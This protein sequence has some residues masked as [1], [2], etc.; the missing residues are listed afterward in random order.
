MRLGVTTLIVAWLCA[1]SCASEKPKVPD[2]Q[3]HWT[4]QDA[5]Q[6]ASNVRMVR[7][8]HGGRMVFSC[9]SGLY[10]IAS[11]GRRSQPVKRD[12]NKPR[13][14]ALGRG[15][16]IAVV[17]S[18]IR[19]ID[20][21]KT[22]ARFERP[23]GHIV[24][25][26]FDD[27]ETR[28]AVVVDGGNVWIFDVKSGQALRGPE[29][30]PRP[31]PVRFVEAP[32]FR[33]LRLVRGRL[34]EI[35]DLDAGSTRSLEFAFDP[36]VDPALSHD[37]DALAAV[38][39]G[40]AIEIRD[41]RDGGLRGVIDGVEKPVTQ[42][43]IS[44]DGSL[45]AA[46]AA[47]KRVE[48]WDTRS[49]T[50]LLGTSSTFSPSGR[51]QFGT[52]GYLLAWTEENLRTVRVWQPV[53]D[54]VKFADD[55]PVVTAGARDVCHDVASLV[56]FQLAA[57]LFDRAAEHVK[58]SQLREA[59][60]LLDSAREMFGDYPGL[61]S[62]YEEIDER[63]Q[64]INSA[65]KLATRVNELEVDG[66][67]AE[68]LAM[69][70][71]Y[72]RSVSQ[73]GDFG[74]GDRAK[75]LRTMLKHLD[76]AKAKLAASKDVDAVV[77]FDKAVALAPELRERFSEY[78]QARERADKALTQEAMQA[79]H[80]LTWARV[81]ELYADLARLRKLDSAENL[82]LGTSL[83][84]L[85]NARKAVEAFESIEPERP[86]YIEARRNLARIAIRDK[87]FAGALRQLELARSRAKDLIDLER[88]YA[89]AQ[90][91][92]GN[93]DA[94]VKA[95]LH[96]AKLEPSNPEPL[97]IVA[98]IEVG[99]GNHGK[100]ARMLQR[101][102]QVSTDPRPDL[103]LK[104]VKAYEHAKRKDEVL[105]AYIGLL[106]LVDANI[107]IPGL[108]DRPRAELLTKIRKLG[109]VRRRGTWITRERFLAEQGWRERDGIWNRPEEDDLETQAARIESEFKNVE[110]RTKTDQSYAA[111]AKD[112]RL[113]VGMNRKEIIEAWGLFRDQNVFVLNE[114]VTYEQL[115]FD[116][117]RQAYLRNGL[118]AYW[119]E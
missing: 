105:Q 58:K 52:D 75:R 101:A 43:R 81:V 109:Y 2:S 39:P 69:L 90:E 19:V 20:H 56:R 110:L 9:D 97:E 60:T 57:K 54:V 61:A 87:D 72:L 94:A 59:R 1:T 98:R 32:G 16:L 23:S 45:L 102:V 77:E 86:E 31:G 53:N 28:L 36:S 96:V 14:V 12:A 24:S 71:T 3:P 95:W 64:A 46:V 108:G 8:G 55:G 70:D 80:D 35:I 118:L 78:D 10:E 93:K 65:E 112:K 76:V 21:E 119:S 62:A 99:R 107:Q 49:R 44:P 17:G 92:N 48:L 63:R 6:A 7:I 15:G 30:M 114:K 37:G 89:Q 29:I 106:Q 26:G 5:F 18:E 74:L 79:F 85:G 50:L 82:R 34:I 88:E 41:G 25:I 4:K 100:A 13:A 73:F 116:N 84:R 103:L 22:V 104:L 111:Q 38:N 66:K 67:Y 83:E 40:G 47:G 27:S 117:G 51:V 68:A 113:L 91:L 33:V 42:M 11:L 115:L